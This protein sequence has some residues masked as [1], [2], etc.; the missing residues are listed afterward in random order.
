MSAE[1][2]GSSADRPEN[3]PEP[4]EGLRLRALRSPLGNPLDDAFP[5]EHV[6]FEIVYAPLIGPTA[7]LVARAMARHLRVAG[8]STTVCPVTLALEVGIRASRT[9]PLGKKS[10]LVH[11]IDRLAHDRIVVRH[12]DRTLGLRLKIPP[13]SGRAL[14]KLPAP[15]RSAHDALVM[16]A[17]PQDA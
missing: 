15:T 5:I 17:K 4:I 16:A 3:E 10:H 1:I 9:D 13:L 8:G 6:Y 7:L 2:S 11:A 12:G 14:D